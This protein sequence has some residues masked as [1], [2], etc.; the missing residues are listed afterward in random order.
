MTSATSEEI[1][2]L[3]ISTADE[4]KL[5]PSS[6]P[7]EF[8]AVDSNNNPVSFPIFATAAKLNLS[9][10]ILKSLD[11]KFSLY[12]YNDSENVRLGLAISILDKSTLSIELEKQEKTFPTDASFLFLNSKPEKTLGDFNISTYKSISIKYINLNSDALPL[13]I[14]YTITDSQF[15]L[16]ASK[17]TLRAI[18]DKNSPAT[19]DE[20]ATTSSSETTITSPENSAPTQIDNTNSTTSAAL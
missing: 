3:L 7:Y 11:E 5:L 20:T 8:L 13:S 14:D 1:S 16:A 12:L 15:I 6:T 9:P 10:A 4:L 2:K 18:I 19:T 17:N